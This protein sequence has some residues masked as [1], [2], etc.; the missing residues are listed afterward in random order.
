MPTTTQESPYDWP[1]YLAALRRVMHPEPPPPSL[2]A[3]WR[4]WWKARTR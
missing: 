2:W 3:R 4:A 1:E